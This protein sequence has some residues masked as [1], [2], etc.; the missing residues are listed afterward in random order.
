LADKGYRGA[1][2]AVGVPFLRPRTAK[3][4]L[5]GFTVQVQRIT[6]PTIVRGKGPPQVCC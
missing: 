4:K 5:A 1:R 3:A 6:H 2:G